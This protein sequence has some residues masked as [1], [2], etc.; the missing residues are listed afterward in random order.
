MRSFLSKAASAVATGGASIAPVAAFTAG[1]ALA[2]ASPTASN[3]FVA[4]ANQLAADAALS[5]TPG[6]TP[7][8]LRTGIGLTPGLR[9]TGSILDKIANIWSN[10]T[11]F[12]PASATPLSPAPD[13]V[14]PFPT[15]YGGGGGGGGGSGDGGGG[16]GGGG[17]VYG[18]PAADDAR[19]PGDDGADDGDGDDGGDGGG[20]G[21]PGDGQSYPGDQDDSGSY[22]EYGSGGP[23]DTFT[24]DQRAISQTNQMF[25]PPDVNTPD[26]DGQVGYDNDDDEGTGGQDYAQHSPPTA[27]RGREDS[28]SFRD[29]A[30]VTIPGHMYTAPAYRP[31]GEEGDD[32]MDAS[33]YMAA[34][35]GD[36]EESFAGF[37]SDLGKSV[38][39]GAAQSALQTANAKLG[40]SGAKKV[41]VGTAPPMSVGKKLF[42]GAVVAVPLL[43]F[44][45]RHKSAPAPA[46]VSNGRR[47]WSY[48]PIVKNRRR[49]R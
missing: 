7:T 21:A 17:G 40:G 27:P 35:N 28:W 18:G 42:I 34:L 32:T 46:V 14:I 26:D 1:R 29:R 31:G 8:F 15:N 11:A 2:N 3:R 44:L 33:G 25:S 41:D 38:A 48:M 6:A 47:R 4:A 12:A 39:K 37:W 13:N 22:S 23:A 30:P 45:T 5:A 49:R 36:S 43:Y 10:P 16:G 20:Q 9:P 24:H 19:A